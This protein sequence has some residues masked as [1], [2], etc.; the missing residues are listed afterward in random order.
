MFRLGELKKWRETGREE[1]AQSEIGTGI[2]QRD[3]LQSGKPKR[4]RVLGLWSA[5]EWR[6]QRDTKSLRSLINVSEE[7]A[8]R[9]EKREREREREREQLIKR[10][11]RKR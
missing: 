5:S 9:R 3:V 6:D 10:A 7:G 1:R 11:F 4:E 8:D 2:N